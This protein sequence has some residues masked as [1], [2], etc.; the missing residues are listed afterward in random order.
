MKNLKKQE[1][2]IDLQI[3]RWQDEVSKQKEQEK[4]V[5]Q[6]QTSAK[7][8]APPSAASQSTNVPISEQI[9]A[10]KEAIQNCNAKKASLIKQNKTKEDEIE[11]LKREAI[12][13]QQAKQKLTNDLN[14]MKTKNKQPSQADQA[15]FEKE[16]A[17]IEKR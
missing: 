10:T 2:H 12:Q 11:T 5:A 13:L 15:L 7:S 1:Y 17:A 4:K 8:G 14:D 9:K 3:K 16:L 6:P